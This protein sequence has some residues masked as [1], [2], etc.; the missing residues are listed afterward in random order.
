MEAADREEPLPDGMRSL[1]SSVA[2]LRGLYG[3]EG[4][5]GNA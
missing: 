3:F 5:P 2:M 1:K 4:Y